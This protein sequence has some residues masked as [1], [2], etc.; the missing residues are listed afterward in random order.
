[1]EENR[2][3]TLLDAVKSVK[4]RSRGA[5]NIRQLVKRFFAKLSNSLKKSQFT[6]P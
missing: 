5:G 1:M 3:R 4:L 6:L 2:V